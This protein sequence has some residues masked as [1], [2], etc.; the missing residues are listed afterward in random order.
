[1]YA[2]LGQLNKSTGSNNNP[3]VKKSAVESGYQ[4][5]AIGQGI[6]ITRLSQLQVIVNLRNER[7]KKLSPVHFISTSMSGQFGMRNLFPV[8]AI[9]FGGSQHGLDILKLRTIRDATGG[10][11]VATAFTADFDQF[12]AIFLDGAGRAGSN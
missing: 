7:A 4:V 8:D 9:F 10:Q 3:A 6:H 11:G 12:A 1:L 2:K 5:F